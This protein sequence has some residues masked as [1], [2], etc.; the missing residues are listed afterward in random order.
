MK[1]NV[2]YITPTAL[3]PQGQGKPN[4]AML[5][6]M[7]GLVCCVLL[8]IGGLGPMTDAW[9]TEEYSHAYLIPLISIFLFLQQTGTLAEQRPVN[10]SVGLIFLLAGILSLMLGELSAIPTIIQYG[11]IIALSGL[12]I[13][14]LGTNGARTCWAAIAYLCFMVPLPTLIQNNLSQDLQI[15]SSNFGVMI[16]RL[17]GI[18][19]YLEGNVI[20]LGT[21]KL[22]VVDACSGLRYL[23]PLMSFGFLIA[24]LYRA[25]LWQRAVIFLSTIPIT[26]FM[27]SVRIGFVGVSVEYFGI[28]A[29]EGFLH[30]FEGWIIFIFC[31]ALLVLVTQILRRATR[32]PG[33]FLDQ[34]NLQLADLSQLTARCKC[35]GTIGRPYYLSLLIIATVTP[36]VLI[37]GSRQEAKPARDRFDTMPLIYRGWVGREGTL[38]Q[39][40]LNKLKLSDYFYGDFTKDLIGPKVNLYIAYYASQ[41]KGAGIHSPKSCIPGGGWEI[42]QLTKHPVRQVPLSSQTGDFIINRAII[43]K[44]EFRNVVY[45]WFQQRGRIVNDE[46]L[47][48]W[49]VLVDSIVANRSDG[50]LVRVS[51]PWPEG[52]ELTDIDQLANE[53]IGDVYPTLVHYLPE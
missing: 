35:I 33:A 10:S 53:F 42:K 6:L 34:L 50:A 3:A 31:L 7:V 51:M 43:Q 23:F 14:V 40:V 39:D 15:I 19:V 46:Y 17:F 13:C 27:N 25:P 18:S 2:T 26:I 30:Y 5:L 24:V 29:A 16:V 37:Y 9:L 20:D 52:I 4:Y 1:S 47:N 36:L 21:L 28:R 32:Q 22:Q 45:Y 11:F 41:K 8:F 38:D 48:R 44:G 49:Y 12:V